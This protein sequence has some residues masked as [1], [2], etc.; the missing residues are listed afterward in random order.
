LRR[1]SRA[2]HVG[3]GTDGPNL[4]GLERLDILKAINGAPAELE[5]WGPLAKPP[6]ALQSSGAEIPAAGQVNLV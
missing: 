4:F 2:T 5:E 3:G 6:P 1:S